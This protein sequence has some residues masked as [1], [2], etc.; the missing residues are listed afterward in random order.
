[1]RASVTLRCIAGCQNARLSE[2]SLRRVVNE[3]I[4]PK[5]RP[6]MSNTTRSRGSVVPYVRRF[7]RQDL[8]T[9]SRRNN[10][11]CVLLF[12]LL[13]TATPFFCVFF[14]L[15]LCSESWRS[16]SGCARV[17]FFLKDGMSLC[18]LFQFGQPYFKLAHFPNTFICAL[19]PANQSCEINGT[20]P[21]TS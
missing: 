21:G 19:Y 7:D 11:P 13:G 3:T 5:H 14:L 6:L 16:L 10:A 8:W 4:K 9:A 2:I 18:Y 20:E 1:M 15:L 12:K 17:T